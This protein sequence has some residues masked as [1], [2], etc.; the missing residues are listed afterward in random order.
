[1]LSSFMKI[2]GAAALMS[3]YLTTNP[4]IFIEH[5]PGAMKSIDRITANSSS[6]NLQLLIVSIVKLR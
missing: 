5:V 3:A 1:M 2:T 6:V 4:D